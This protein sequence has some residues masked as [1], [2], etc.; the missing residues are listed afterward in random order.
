MTP[1][2][3]GL[4]AAAVVL[5]ATVL[6]LMLRENGGSAPRTETGIGT[7]PAPTAVS[8]HVPESARCSDDSHGQMGFGV[9]LAP[10]ATGSRTIA[11]AVRTAKFGPRDISAWHIAARNTHDAFLLSGPRYLHVTRLHD[12]TWFVDSGGKCGAGIAVLP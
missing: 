12:H 2:L 6:V 4:A 5:G 3:A 1:V 10:G 9:S 7:G 8:K 11:Q